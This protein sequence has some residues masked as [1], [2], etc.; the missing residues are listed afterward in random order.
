MQFREVAMTKLSSIDAEA[1]RLAGRAPEAEQ[2]A[3]QAA[4]I[5][6]CEQYWQELRS[7][8]PPQPL[9]RTLWSITPPLAELFVDM[10]RRGDAHLADFLTGRKATRALAALVLAEIERGNA[11]GAHI[12]YEAMMLFDTPQAGLV[13]AERVAAAL[14]APHPVRALR[15]PA[16]RAVLWKALAEIVAHTARHDLAAVNAVIS[17]LAQPAMAPLDATLET[18]RAAVKAV[19][20]QFL[21]FKADTLSFLAHDHEHKPVTRKH[22]AELLAE[23][24]QLRLA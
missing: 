10:V 23:I 24:R 17:L 11:E 14:R 15:P 20:V 9:A 12:A 1:R 8:Q 19:G 21:G 3:F 22:L 6:C 16:A 5:N 13:H 18:L 4:L 2:R 7:P